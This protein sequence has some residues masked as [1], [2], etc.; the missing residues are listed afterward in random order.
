M[1]IK[2][3]VIATIAYFDLFDYPVTQNEIHLFLQRSHNR[4]KVGTALKYLVSEKFLYRFNEFYS[5][6][7]DPSAV[8]RRRRGNRKAAQ[9]MVTANKVSALISA[10]P[11]V[12]C[13]TISGSLSKNFADENSDIDFFIICSKNRLWISR[14][15]LML[16][17]KLAVLLKKQH[18]FCMNYFVDEAA[19]EIEEKNVYTA[20]EIITLIPMRG[21]T[22]FKDF[23]KANQWVEDYLPN[24]NTQTSCF[25]ETKTSVVKRTLEW[26]F[27]FSVFNRLE[28]SLQRITAKR[29]RAK[30]LKGKK[31][32]HGIVVS[33][34]TSDHFAKHDPEKFQFRLLEKYQSRVRELFKQ[35]ED[36]LA[37][38]QK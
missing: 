24:Y 22:T 23:C 4:Q 1:P 20:T 8:E 3:D 31:N 34:R 33:M 37:V 36:N 12:R 5:L 6:R 30:E 28:N 32:T 29:Y 21:K 19:L 11:Y 13:V 14:T 26:V 25:K 15:L 9:M 38:L 16:F 27:D 2:N 17:R 18:Y 35:M 10:F 7:D